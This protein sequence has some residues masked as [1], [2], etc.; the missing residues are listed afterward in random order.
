[1]KLSSVCYLC[2]VPLCGCIQLSIKPE[3]V[4]SDGVSAGKGVY[5]SIK[6]SRAGLSE[7][8]FTHTLAIPA[9]GDVNAGVSQ[10]LESVR[11][12]ASSA[13][14]GESLQIVSESSEL[15]DTETGMAARCT[16]TA[17]M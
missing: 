14:E 5:Q 8:T 13:A 4:V 17:V 7:R 1:M 12:M 16:L 15:I 10:C 9:Q 3:K 11:D 2:L 6:R